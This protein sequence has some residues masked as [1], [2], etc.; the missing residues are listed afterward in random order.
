MQVATNLRVGN[1]IS[2]KNDICR[3]ISVDHVTPGKGR[4]MI[5]AKMV[6][7]T[8][9]NNVVYRFRPD[10]KFELVRLEEKEMEYL[11]SD[12]S[13]HHFMDIET[14]EQISLSDEFVGDNIKY[15]VPS[16]HCTIEFHEGNPIGITPPPQVELKVVE[17]EPKLKGATAAGSY[18]PAKLETGLVIQ[19]PP[20]VENGTIIRIDTEQKKYL[21]RV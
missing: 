2:H 14:F 10:E 8:K 18:K 17:T 6:S 3:V 9:G 19:V 15:I 1:I 21:E 5:H 16:A 4:G 11:Y 20:F 7:L 12:G 13:E